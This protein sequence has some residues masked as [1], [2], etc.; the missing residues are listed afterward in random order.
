VEKCHHEHEE[1]VLYGKPRM[2]APEFS[3]QHYAGRVTYAVKGFLDKNKDTLRADVVELLIT[4]KNK[5]R[6][7]GSANL[8]P[9]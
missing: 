5:V 6:G 4:S 2:V 7:R 1:N 8:L 3:I 9:I